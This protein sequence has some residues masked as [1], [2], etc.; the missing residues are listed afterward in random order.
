MNADLDSVETAIAAIAR[1]EFVVVVD[2]ADRENEG[3]LIIAAEKMTPE[4]MAFLVRHSSGVVCISLPAQRLQAL[5]LGLMVAD[6]QESHSTAF[7]VTVDFRH[8]TST[9]I[10]AAD[11]SATVRA[12]ADPTTGPADFVRPGHL[13]PLRY[14]DGGV[15]VRPGHTEAAGDL[16]RLAGLQPA[17]VLCEIV[18]EDGSMARGEALQRFASLHGLPIISIAQLIDYR[19]RTESTVDLA[20]VTRLPTRYGSFRAHAYRDRISGQEHLALVMGE[21]REEPAAL[22]R[23]HS[24]CL[25]GDLLG[26]LRC[27]CGEQLDTALRRIAQN[28]CGVL[29]YLRGHEGRGIGLSMKLR[30]YQLQDQGLD[31]VDANLA[32]GQPVDARRYEAAAH[33][34]RDLGVKGVRLMS[35]N[36]QKEAALLACGLTVVT[37]ALEVPPHAGNRRYLDTKRLRL[38]HRI[39]LP[40]PLLQ[41]TAHD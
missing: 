35:N 19:R 25:T 6:N 17:G 20:G 8:G 39:E 41:R 22:T 32:L 33:I 30:A 24:E 34:L 27:D 10:S 18:D 15:L 31:T 13:F 14:R 3:D 40:A 38:G 16:A 23:L 1:G 11:R 29:V 7:T 9:G 37:Q 2:D 26:S 21:V 36:P 12:L 4:K 28:R 5:N